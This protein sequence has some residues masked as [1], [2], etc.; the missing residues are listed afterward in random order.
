[1]VQQS[2]PSAAARNLGSAA[3]AQAIAY[4][5]SRSTLRMWLSRNWIQGVRVGGRTLYDLDSVAA[6]IQPVGALSEQERV[7][8]AELVAESPDPDDDQIA[9]VRS[10]IHRGSEG[11]LP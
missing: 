4:G 11:A 8:I 1:M 3:Q 6:M 5:I 9:K 7:A 2:P 10:I